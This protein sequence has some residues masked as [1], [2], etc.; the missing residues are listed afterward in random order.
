MLG[1]S[2]WIVLCFAC[3]ALAFVFATA[4]PIF[5]F[6]IGLAA[7]L[8]AAWYYFYFFQSLPTI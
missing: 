7:S 1:W 3:S 4:V 6:L 5:S 8:F 2:V